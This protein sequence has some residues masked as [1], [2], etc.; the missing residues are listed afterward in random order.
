MNVKV[1]LTAC[2]FFFSFFA[3]AQGLDLDGWIDDWRG[4]AEQRNRG[5]NP[6]FDTNNSDL[7]RS[8]N[9]KRARSFSFPPVWN[10]GTILL[11]DGSLLKGAIKHNIKRDVVQIQSKDTTRI[12]AAHQIRAFEIYKSRPQ[13]RWANPNLKAKRTKYYSLPYGSKNGYARPK[14]FEVLMEGNTSLLRRWVYGTRSSDRKLY[15]RDSDGGITQIKKRRG[16]VIASFD[17]RHDELK[18]FAKRER[19]DMYKIGDVM[20]LV[21]EYNKLQEH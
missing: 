13:L 10:T 2:F 18:L 20:R 6:N 5:V 21:A 11:S 1:S 17:G 3:S 15:L 19:L 7:F 4:L 8:R 16:Q 12:L 9:G 14:L